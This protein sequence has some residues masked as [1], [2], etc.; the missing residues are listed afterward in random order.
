MGR[1][2]AR[3]KRFATQ[4]NAKVLAAVRKLA[5]REGRQIQD[6]VDEALVDLLSKRRFGKPRSQV[7]E[8]YQR[9]HG[10]YGELYKK[11]AQ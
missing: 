7:M 9:S 3:R 1:D 10:R 8:A 2:M 5:E 11:L 6:L 4:V